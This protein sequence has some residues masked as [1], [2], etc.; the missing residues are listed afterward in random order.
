MTRTLL[1]TFFCV[2]VSLQMALNISALQRDGSMINTTRFP[3]SQTLP[4]AV[5]DFC[6]Y[7]LYCP[8][9]GDQTNSA[10]RQNFCCI[11]CDCSESC[12]AAGTCCIDVP[13]QTFSANKTDHIKENCVRT[14][15]GNENVKSGLREINAYMLVQDCSVVNETRHADNDVIGKCLQPE[16][17]EINEI[18]P[19]YSV[20]TGQH[21]RNLFCAAC[22]NDEN[23]TVPWEIEVTSYT[24]ENAMKTFVKVYR[25]G[26]LL[27]TIRNESKLLVL[28]KPVNN[29]AKHCFNEIISECPNTIPTSAFEDLCRKVYSPVRGGKAIYK[30]VFCLKCNEMTYSGM[31]ELMCEGVLLTASE[32]QFSTILGPAAYSYKSGLTSQTEN[33]PKELTYDKALVRPLY[34]KVV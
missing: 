19:V 5:L 28:F 33:C 23:D 29:R 34:L 26:D 24:F 27:K 7:T 30:N 3:E 2:S 20:K 11:P 16:E 31:T 13:V 12:Y 9:H 21:Y 15:V 1:E 10:P 6:P 32:K 18:L 14:Y 17:N 8:V 4:E 25:V 22:N